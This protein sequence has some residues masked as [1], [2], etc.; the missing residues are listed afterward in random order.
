MWRAL[1]SDRTV[2]MQLQTLHY[3]QLKVTWTFY[4]GG[5]WSLLARK[6]SDVYIQLDFCLGWNFA[7]GGMGP[8]LDNSW[9]GLEKSGAFRPPPPLV[10]NPDL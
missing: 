5:L 3:R 8:K 9:G 4:S 2:V 6:L 10:S 1:F 7:W